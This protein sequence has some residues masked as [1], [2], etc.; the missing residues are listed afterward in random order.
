M[1][2]QM[3]KTKG[4]G[5]AKIV[6]PRTLEAMAV[7]GMTPAEIA[8]Y[9]GLTRQGMVRVIENNPELKDAFHNGKDHIMIKAI[10]VVYNKIDADDMFAAVYFLNN[11][12]GWKEAKYE[13]EKPAIDGPRVIIYLPDNQRDKIIDETIIDSE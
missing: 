2:N 9:Y 5:I 3:A 4:C 12:C 10:N 8:R 6:D 13:K 11:R 1:V 7:A